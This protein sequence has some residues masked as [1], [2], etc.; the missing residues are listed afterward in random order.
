MVEQT[1]RHFAGDIGM[2]RVVQLA[3]RRI[4]NAPDNIGEVLGDALAR[5]FGRVARMKEVSEDDAAA[6]RDC[7]SQ[8]IFLLHYVTKPQLVPI[9]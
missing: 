7:C 6:V 8:I 1:D 4:V 3:C 2:S 5:A 9:F